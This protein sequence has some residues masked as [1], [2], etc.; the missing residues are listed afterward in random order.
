MK[1]LPFSVLSVLVLTAISACTADVALDEGDTFDGVDATIEWTTDRNN[2]VA[3]HTPEYDIPPY[4]DQTLCYFDTYSGEEAGVFWAGFYQNVAYGH[5]VVL[6][7]SS[8]DEDD[9]PDGTIADCTTTDATIMTEAR[10]FLF[11][12]DVTGERQPEMLLPEG[13]AVKLNAGERFVIQ[14]HHINTTDTSIRVNDAVFLQ[15]GA[16]D[17]VDTFAAPWVHTQTDLNLPIGHSVEVVDCAFDQDLTLLSM[18]GH[19]HEWGSAYAIDHVDLDGVSNRVYD[20][21]EWSVEFR[22]APPVNVY[23]MGE[24]EVKAGERLVTTCE[25]ENDTDGPLGFPHE[26]CATVGFA[27]PLAV[28]VICEP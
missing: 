9:W 16:I 21:P 20:I 15:T 3:F 26:M 6:M 25:W 22:D 27:Y 19:L 23:E 28:T 4:T 1:T 5:H 12:S 17:T 8:A 13:M 11:A 24:F 7:S 14:S 10:P 2:V 18:L